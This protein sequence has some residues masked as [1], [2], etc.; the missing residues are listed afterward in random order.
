MTRW[1]R[2]ACRTMD[3]HPW[4]YRES[5]GFD[6]CSVHSRCRRCGGVGL[7]DSQGNLFAVQYPDEVN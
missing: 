4:R 1:A 7:E 2:F 3:W 6:G 5:V